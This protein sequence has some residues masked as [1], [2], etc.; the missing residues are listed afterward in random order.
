MCSCVNLT[1]TRLIGLPTAGDVGKALSE[2][3][4]VDMSVYFKSFETFYTQLA[5]EKSVTC[6]TT[7]QEMPSL[8]APSVVVIDVS[9]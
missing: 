5:E 4:G 9:V 8:P 1:L 7:Q 2:G 3:Q 6:S